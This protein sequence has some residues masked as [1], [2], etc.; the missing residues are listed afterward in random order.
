M[1]ESVEITSGKTRSSSQSRS[2][3]KAAFSVAFAAVLVTGS[4]ELELADASD[5]AAAATSASAA[6]SVAN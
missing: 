1:T 6:D 3:R 2:S 4:V 5:D